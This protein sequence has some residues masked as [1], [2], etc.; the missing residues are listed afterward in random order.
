MEQRKGERK[1]TYNAFNK[2]VRIKDKT[3]TKNNTKNSVAEHKTL[4]NK[5]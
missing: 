3:N 4:K 5:V 2:E 1:T